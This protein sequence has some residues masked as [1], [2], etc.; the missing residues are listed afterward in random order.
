MSKK[1]VDKKKVKEKKPT[2]KLADKTLMTK[3]LQGIFGD[4]QK[5]TL[6]RYA[7]KAIEINNLEEKYQKMSDK[8][9]ANQTEVLREKLKNLTKSE[10]NKEVA[11]KVKAKHLSSKNPRTKS[12]MNFLPMHSQSSVKPQ[13]AN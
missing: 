12:S 9:L 4:A 5:K 3:I 7:K 6:V 8:E 13:I 10:Q 1:E 11:E 2:D